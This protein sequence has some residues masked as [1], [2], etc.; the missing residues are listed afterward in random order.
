MDSKLD[1]INEGALDS[2]RR[3]GACLR[4]RGVRVS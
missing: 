1:V 2:E 4:E 3:G